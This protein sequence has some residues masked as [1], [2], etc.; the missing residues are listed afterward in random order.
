MRILESTL[1]LS[2]V[3]LFAACQPES[4]TGEMTRRGYEL[5]KH[6]S[7]GGQMPQPGEYA[8]FQIVMRHG[9]SILN[10]SYGSDQI[11]PSKMSL[12]EIILV[13]ISTVQLP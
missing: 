4:T 10:T 13:L 5:V 1:I 2:L 3:V 8:Y 7:T 6:V 9:D 11:L 12:R